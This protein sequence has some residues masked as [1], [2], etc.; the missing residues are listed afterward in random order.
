MNEP[1]Y[2]DTCRS[3]NKPMTTWGVARSLFMYSLLTGWFW[4][5]ATRR[6]V[7]GILVAIACYSLALWATNKEPKIVAILFRCAMQKTRYDPIK[8]S[9]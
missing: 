1:A 3:L 8:S 2:H 6:G 9:W 4:F 7:V 5:I